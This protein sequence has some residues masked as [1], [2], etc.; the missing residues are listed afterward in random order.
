MAAHRTA[1]YK[2]TLFWYG[3]FCLCWITL[4]LYAG[5]MTT[6]LRAGMAF[7]DWPLSDGSLNPAGWRSESDKLA[8]HSH[9]LLGMKVGL[10][11]IVLMVW[12]QIKESRRWLRRLSIILVLAVV[13]QGLLGGARVVFDQLNTRTPSNLVAQTFAVL[14]ACGA[15]V[16]LC[17]LVSIV[18]ALSKGWIANK[19]QGAK[20][21]PQSIRRFSALAV[22]AV[23]L[24]IRIGAVMRHAE[25]GMAIP[26]FPLSTETSL[27]P[28]VWSFDVS[29]HFA[30]RVG[31][32]LLTALFLYIVYKLI[33]G[34]GGQK[35][36]VVGISLTSLFIAQVSLGALT[37][38]TV[39]NS[40]V[41]TLHHLVGAF[42]LA[43]TFAISFVANR[44]NK[45]DQFP[46]ATAL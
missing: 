16:V 19:R 36:L 41:A 18:I 13:S 42:L 12:L 10:L 4:L 46:V 14:H 15:M 32:V 3:V 28:P 25:A 20:V 33:F 7:L 22:I 37:I 31:A 5:G 6:S 29:I 30:H 11:S 39:K 34:M 27:L 24:Q 17:L 21:W 35:R 23:F 45:P 26:H 40:H 1:T 9:R 44:K 38:W 43:Y 8:E 2:P